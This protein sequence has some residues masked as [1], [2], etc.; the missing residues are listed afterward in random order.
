MKRLL[1]LLICLCLL[2]IPAQAE[3]YEKL[4]AL[5]F[6]DGPSGRFTRAL[7]EGLE[8]RDAKATFFLCGYRMEQDPALTKRIFSEGHEIGLHGYSH[9]CMKTMCQADIHR[10]LQKVA[11]LLPDGCQAV[12]LRSPGGLCSNDVRAAARSMNLSIL[13]WSVDPKD[14]ATNNADAVEKEVIDHVRDGDVI[15][16]HDMSD[17]SVKAALLIIDELQEEGFRFVTVSELAK[18]K[19][20]TPEAGKEY[21]CF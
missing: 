19:G 4:I 5:T 18:A 10:E 15:L 1:V 13:S 8:E 2:C 7:L 12:F 6:D 11:S 3:E 17:S 9:K 14:W 20:I 21:H 16:L